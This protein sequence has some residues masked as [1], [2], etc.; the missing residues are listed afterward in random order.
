MK[1]L[2][3]QVVAEDIKRACALSPEQRKARAEKVNSLLMEEYTWKTIG[4]G[5]YQFF[6]GIINDKK[7]TAK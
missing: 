2:T 6:E 5:I 1:E 3:P 7:G 4:E